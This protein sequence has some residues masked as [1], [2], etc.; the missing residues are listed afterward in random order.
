MNTMK[1]KKMIKANFHGLFFSACALLLFVAAQQLDPDT[2]FESDLA[3][4]RREWLQAAKHCQTVYGGL[5][6]TAEYGE[7]GQLV[8]VSRR[9][10]VLPYRVASK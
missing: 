4:E 8:C 3:K 9:G 10:E 2:A 5:Q 7:S 6:A 1:V